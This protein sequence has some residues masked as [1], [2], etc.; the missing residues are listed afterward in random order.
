ML[1]GFFIRRPIFAIVIS[2]VITLAGLLALSAIPIAQYPNITPPQVTVTATYPGASAETIAATIAQPIEVQ[3]NGVPG[4]LYMRST[5]SSSGTY[6]LQV[7]FAIGTDPNIDQV[8]VQNRVQLAN[9]QLPTEVQQEGLVIRAASSNFVLAVN[10]YSPDDRYDQLFISNYAYMHL[11]QQIA[12]TAGVGDTQIFG[13][14]QYAMRVW[15]DPKRMTAL[16]ITAQD[17]VAAIQTQNLQVAAGQIGQPPVSGSQQQQLTVLA[18]GRLSDPHEFAGIIVRTNRNGG[19]V[20]VSDIAKVELAAQQYTTSS[21]LDGKPSA[22]LA[23][24]QSPDANALGLADSIQQK[25]QALSQQFPPGLSYTIVYNATDFVRADIDEILRT[26]AITL[27]LVTAVVYVFLQDW[28]A[29]LI[30]VIAIPVSLIGVFAVLYVVGYSANTVNLFAIVLAITLV[31]DDAIVVVENVTRHLEERPDQ[32]VVEATEQAMAEITGP[33]VATSLVLVAVFAPVG[34]ISGIIGALYRQFAVT[35]SAAIVISAIN[36]LTLSPALCALILGRSQG[37]RSF[38]FRGFNRG[39]NFTRDRYGDMVRFLSRWLPLAAV[40][41]LAAFGLAYVALASTPTAFLPEEDQGHFYVDVQMP[42]GA[43]LVRTERVVEQVAAMLRQ[44]PGVAHTIELAGQSIIAGVQEPN[45]GSVIAIMRPWSER[46]DSQSIPSVMAVMQPRFNAIPAAQIVSFNPPAIPGVSTTGGVNFVLEGRGG[47]STQQLAAATRGLIFAANQDPNLSS[48]FTA[49]SASVPQVMVHVDTTRAALMGVTPADIY[50]TLQANLGGQFVNDFNYQ[51]FVFQVVMQADAQFR[52]KISDIDRL[53]VRNTSGT[54]VP[55]NG[56]VTVSTVQGADAVTL[57]NLSPAVLING[58]AAPGRSSG[59][60]IAAMERIA[61]QHLPAG[62]GF[63]WTGMSYQELLSAGQ[64]ASAYLFSIVFS[65]L[66]LAALY[67]SWTLPL[68]VLL[69]VAFAAL[70]GLIGLKVRGIALDVYGQIGLVLLIG[71]AAKN[72]ILIVEFA[73]DRLAGGSVSVPEAAEQG[74]RTRYR[75]VMM[76]SLAF[77]VGMIPLVVASG[78]GA[79][80][81]RSIGTTVFGGMVL[82][83]FVG[84]LFVPALFVAFELIGRATSRFIQRRGSRART[85][86]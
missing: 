74:A 58:A 10:L 13:Q 43:S 44:T 71:L 25:M 76:T 82:A 1:S 26:L 51:N 86:K 18:P 50:A 80:S 84:V 15:L 52:A 4:M 36:A 21:A 61:M 85:A 41:I 31:V 66:F 68:S 16:G 37:D 55:L 57:Y 65:Y 38:V 64:E 3:V 62:F 77:I 27:V 19:V 75:A 9:A 5:S 11:Q 23:V 60:A 73:K 46:D 67:E 69:P 53:Y 56:L 78:A 83:S 24:F 17:I 45:A 32:S 14:R 63:D 72:A 70:G 8:N 2:L 42:N 59:Q 20:R 7:T 39:F 54:M 47:Q 12:R 22:T 30:P 28:R 81:R 40:G 35:I 34:F 79:G 29:T 49:F 33:V 6:S 48:V